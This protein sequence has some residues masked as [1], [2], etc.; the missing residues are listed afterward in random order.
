MIRAKVALMYGPHDL[1]VEEVTMRDPKDDEV[2]IKMKAAG[3][4]GSDVECFE[5]KSKEGRYDIAP[6]TPGHEWSGEVAATGKSVTTVKVGD[7]VTGDCVLPCFRCENCKRGLM[8]AACLQFREVGFTPGAGG[9]MGEYL[10]LEEPYVHPLPKDWTF[11]EGAL[12]E[13]FSVSH[14]GVWGPGGY[15]EASDDVVVFGSGPIG[16]GVLIVC[17]AANAKV[18]VLEPLARRREV[19]KKFGAD[20]AL[21]PYGVDN[22]IAEIAKNTTTS[23][24]ATLVVEASGN[25]DAIGWMFDVAGLQPRMRMI[26]HSIGRKVPVEIGKTIWRGISIYGQGGTSYDMPRTINFMDRIRNRIDLKGLITHQYPFAKVN[27]AFDMAVHHKADAI[28][29]MLTF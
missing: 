6:Y 15:V 14:W 28:K 25:D 12:V 1:R 16:L 21:D 26:G 23:R 2:L 27:E 24:G 19:A 9:G 17:K 29:V 20:V 18:I 5:G 8:P 13:P 7:K 22:L 11:E 10:L 4:C 3:I